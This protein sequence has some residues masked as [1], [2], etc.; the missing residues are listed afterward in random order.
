MYRK[1]DL[2]TTEIQHAITNDFP[3]LYAHVEL[4]QPCENRWVKSSNVHRISING[5]CTSF[6]TPTVLLAEDGNCL[7]PILGVQSKQLAADI[8][9]NTADDELRFLF[10]EL[11]LHCDFSNTV[12]MV[13]FRVYDHPEDARFI[14]HIMAIQKFQNPDD[15]PTEQPWQEHAKP[16]ENSTRWW[17][18]TTDTVNGVYWELT[19]FPIGFRFVEPDERGAFLW[20]EKGLKF[21]SYE[22]F[23]G[24]RKGE[25]RELC[26]KLLQARETGTQISETVEPSEPVK[27]DGEQAYVCF[28][29]STSVQNF[30][31]QV[32]K[33]IA[34]LRNYEGLQNLESYTVTYVALRA[35]LQL[36]ATGDKRYTVAQVERRISQFERL[37]SLRETYASCFKLMQSEIESVCGFL[38]INNVRFAEIEIPARHSV[39]GDKLM[40]VHQFAYTP[41]GVVDA[42]TWLS[43]EKRAF[44]EGN[45]FIRKHFH[46]ELSDGTLR[47]VKGEVTNNSAAS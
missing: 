25:V 12:E 45:N 3:G 38:S 34:A 43:E 26:G 30:C 36:P 18:A 19:I 21:R 14:Y 37:A 40:E 24:A 42:H 15:E 20:E 9:I 28:D 27:T 11:D 10:G 47:P 16:E 4:N 7:D 32:N 13:T 44:N 35:Y 17:T 2:S 33:R 39:P 1:N 46:L 29:D 8:G 6:W 23:L 22:R 41:Q 31:E 5:L